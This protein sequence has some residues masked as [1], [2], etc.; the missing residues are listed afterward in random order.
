[1][2]RIRYCPIHAP[3]R[4]FEPTQLYQSMASS[5]VRLN[6]AATRGLRTQGK[7]S[8]GMLRV[9]KEMYPWSKLLN[10]L[11]FTVF[12]TGTSFSLAWYLDT[13]NVGAGM[14][15]RD[16]DTKVKVMGGIIALNFLFFG[17][18]RV[19]ESLKVASRGVQFLSRYALLDARVV[20]KYPASV[21][22][23]GFAHSEI[24]HIALNMM[25]LYSF[26]SS[27]Y[28]LLGRNQFLAVYGSALC[29]S[30]MGQLA[31]QFYRARRGAL[32]VP[33]LGASGGIYTLLGLVAWYA[34]NS[35]VYIIFLPFIPIQLGYAFT[36]MMTVDA[37]G[38]IRGWSTFGHA[39]HFTGGS[40][41]MLY[42]AAQI[43]D[44]WLSQ[45]RKTMRKYLNKWGR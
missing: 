16:D 29:W 22:T 31:A 17:A 36:G 15:Q 4:H 35:S 21:L 44:R 30:G 42:G 1:M 26:G 14:E 10:P 25:G 43:P 40:L 24:W 3:T 38:L 32:P 41:A 28:D 34:P 27:I 13:K 45:R 23:H 7:A 20:H 37:I 18:L 2:L 33:S 6:A 11:A 39:A 5:Q 8:F 9:Q 12:V 19:S